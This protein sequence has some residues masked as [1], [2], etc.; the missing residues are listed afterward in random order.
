MTRIYLVLVVLIASARIWAVDFIPHSIGVYVTPKGQNF[1]SQDLG[2][3]FA[4]NGISIDQAYFQSLQHE[5]EELELEEMLGSQEEL[6]EVIVKLKEGL[7]RY[8]IGLDLAAHKFQ[9]DV[10]ELDLKLDWSRLAVSIEKPKYDE[11]LE[12]QPTLILN[13]HVVLDSFQLFIKEITARD[14]NNPIFGDVGINHVTLWTKPEDQPF[15]LNLPI[16]FYQNGADDFRVEA[17]RPDTNLDALYIR[18]DYVSPMRLPRVEININGNEIVVNQDEV[19]LLFKEKKDAIFQTAQRELQIWIDENAAE[20]IN[21]FI[22]EKVA[23][24][25]T[26]A[27]TMLPPGAP[28]EFV[29]TFD[30]GMKI[31]GVGFQED[32]VHIGLDAFVTDPLKNSDFKLNPSLIAQR[33]PVLSNGD[34]SKFDLGLALNMGFVNKIIHL[35]ANRGYFKDVELENGEKIKLTKTPTLQLAQTKP[36][37]KLEIEYTVS[38][39]Q[40][41]FVKNPIRISFDM[42]VDF[43]V[44]KNGQVMLVGNGIDI[45]SVFLDSKYIRAFSGTV[46][47]AAKSKIEEMQGDLRGYV[48]A[49]SLPLPQALF[50]LPMVPKKALI[51]KNG[52]LLVYLDLLNL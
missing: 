49:D 25:L 30:W 4:N 21:T 33:T 44:D 3:L 27:S 12:R 23:T 6:K 37:L 15:Y 17:G 28:D 2:V 41:I 43:T 51:E 52:Y 18:S 22:K 14:L 26:E 40:A 47:K 39:F 20:L 5:T 19:E 34:S 16:H 10:K 9:I 7:R 36:V 46:R 11:T 24:G 13:L 38:G 35:S 32:N 29:Q 50:G 31:A 48:I 42:L 1:F 8:L 45:S